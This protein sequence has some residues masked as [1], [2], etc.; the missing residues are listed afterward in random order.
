MTTQWVHKFLKMVKTWQTV[1]FMTTT[2][3]THSQEQLV[4]ERCGYSVEFGKASK[5]TKCG[6]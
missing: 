3:L 6:V 2:V 1:D 5:P 4:C